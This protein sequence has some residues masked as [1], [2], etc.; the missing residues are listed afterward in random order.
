MLNFIENNLSSIIVGAIVFIIV[1]AVLIKLI[2]DK[3]NHKS[4]CAA[5]CSGCPMSGECHK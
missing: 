4:S 5:G 3:K 1:G 2:R